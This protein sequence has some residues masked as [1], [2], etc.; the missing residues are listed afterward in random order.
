MTH[1]LAVDFEAPPNAYVRVEELNFR[2]CVQLLV[3]CFHDV[4]EQIYEESLIHLN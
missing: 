3:F 4:A 2:V 1:R